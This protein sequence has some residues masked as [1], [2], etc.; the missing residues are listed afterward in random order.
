MYD[1]VYYI[2][3]KHVTVHYVHVCFKQRVF[4]RLQTMWGRLT[5]EKIR[6]LRRNNKERR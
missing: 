6:T 4:R 5:G 3:Y 1:I 2:T